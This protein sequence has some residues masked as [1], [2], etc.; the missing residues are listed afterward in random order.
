MTFNPFD[1]CLFYFGLTRLTYKYNPNRPINIF[2]SA[3]IFVL[4]LW[5]CREAEMRGVSETTNSRVA[6]YSISSLGIC[7]L[8]SSAQL[9]YLTR[10]FQKKKLI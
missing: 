8:A 10:F 5:L 2:T 7:I 4:F 9:W 6:W 1:P 3:N